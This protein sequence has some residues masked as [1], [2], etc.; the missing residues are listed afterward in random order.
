MN[1]LVTGGAGY[2]GTPLCMRLA[3]SG[4]RVLCWDP[5]FFGFHFPQPLQGIEL[6]AERVQRLGVADLERFAP[7]WVL[8]LSG[9]SN[10]PMA[11]FA[12]ELNWEENTR[13]TE[14][15]GQLV[16][17]LGVPLL[18]AS[19]ASVYGFQPDVLLTEEADVAPIGHYSESKA[20]A[21]RWLLDN[22]ERVFCLRQATVMG[23]SPRMRFDLLTNGMTLTAW[24]QGKIPVLYGGREARP[25]VHIL[26]LVDAYERVLATPALQRGVYNV[27]ATND[28]VLDV[29][30]AIRNQLET[31]HDRRIELD[32]TDEARKH[33]SYALDSE[34]LRTRTGWVPA[35]DVDA[36]VRE[37]SGLLASGS[38][39][40]EDPRTLNIRWMKLLVEAEAVLQRTGSLRPPSQQNG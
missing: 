32:V 28:N 38:L 9:L 23:P 17:A 37:L 27:S 35:R 26:D 12:P 11:N 4:H 2:I 13:A 14:H 18:F 1:I 34:K 36:T 5:G 24:T 15:V 16:Q 29:A 33:R 25:Q 7:D 8:H 6:R 19:S 20:A 10:D 30:H 40:W 22:V 39:D 31:E 3:Q 21:E